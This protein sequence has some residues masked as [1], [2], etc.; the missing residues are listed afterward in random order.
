MLFSLFYCTNAFDQT[1]LSGDAQ[2]ANII[3]ALQRD[4][5]IPLRITR[6]CNKDSMVRFRNALFESP[7]GPFGKLVIA[8]NSFINDFRIT[9]IR[10]L[11]Y[12]FHEIV[13]DVEIFLYQM[14]SALKAPAFLTYSNGQMDYVHH[15]LGSPTQLANIFS[16]EHL[17]QKSVKLSGLHF[18]HIPKPG[19]VLKLPTTMEGTSG[20][21]VV[22]TLSID[23]S[24]V[25]DMGM[26][27]IAQVEPNRN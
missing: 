15:I 18:K 2:S 4:I 27:Q 14:L 1:L 17:L 10:R 23:L 20:N 6:F 26:K 8:L 9:L 12:I 11:H 3:N 19:L 5:V 22:P 16:I 24:A 21:F 7:H 25:L 13:T